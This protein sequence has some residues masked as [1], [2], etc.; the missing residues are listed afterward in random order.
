MTM[1]LIKYRTPNVSYN[2]Y[3]V[4]PTLWLSDLLDWL[5]L[6]EQATVIGKTHNH[7]GGSLLPIN[8]HSY[9]ACQEAIH[10]SD[11]MAMHR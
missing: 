9:R 6:S 10:I 7:E 11:L 3:A 1:T 5:R 4:V 2:Q 8:W